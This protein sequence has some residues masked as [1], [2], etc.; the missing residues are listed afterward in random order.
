MCLNKH[1]DLRV[2]KDF[3]LSSPPARKPREFETIL[4]G[5]EGER[6]N[7][8]GEERNHARD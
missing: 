4:A 6:K 8:V 1:S 3:P 5:N 2:V 7:G